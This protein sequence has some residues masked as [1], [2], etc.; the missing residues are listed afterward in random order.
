MCL[1]GLK[2]SP[3]FYMA[4]LLGLIFFYQQSLGKSSLS[5]NLMQKQEAL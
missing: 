3:T 2:T 1:Y 5:S 4:D